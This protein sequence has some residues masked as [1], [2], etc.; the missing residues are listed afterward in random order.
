MAVRERAGIGPGKLKIRVTLLVLLA[1]MLATAMYFVFRSSGRQKAL[2]DAWSEKLVRAEF[3]ANTDAIVPGREFL[4]GV[5]FRI[6]PKWYI[7][8]KDPGDAGLPTTVDLHL[9]GNI[10]ADPVLYPEPVRFDQ[11]GGIVGYGYKEEVM[12]V[13]RVLPPADLP[14]G[15]P[16]ILQAHARWLACKGKCILGEQQLELSLPSEKQARASNEALFKTWLERI[17][18][19]WKPTVSAHNYQE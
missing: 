19:E 11:P 2:T 8:W 6:A 18:S 4:V 14:L 17:P 1:C 10:T 3:L 13:A 16:V 15:G 7:Y 5:H 12:L 9:P